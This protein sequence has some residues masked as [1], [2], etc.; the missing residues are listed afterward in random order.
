MRETQVRSINSF[1]RAPVG[2]YSA[3]ARL[4]GGLFARWRPLGEGALM[5]TCP[6]CDGV[7]LVRRQV[8]HSG[9]TKEH[10]VWVSRP[11]LSCYG[12]GKVQPLPVSGKERA[13]A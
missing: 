12:A 8:Q 4:A 1:C 7:G 9:F 6:R 3:G 2:V 5:T 10:L 13:A 11:C